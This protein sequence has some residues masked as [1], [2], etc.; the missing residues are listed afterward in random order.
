MKVEFDE[1][2]KKYMDD[3][4]NGVITDALF[5]ADT[6]STYYIEF[7]ATD[8]GKANALVAE[9]LKPDTFNACRELGIDV[10]CIALSNPDR[11]KAAIKQILQNAINDLDNII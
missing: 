5:V 6:E 11:K 2:T 10:N 4:N 3:I 8:L 1:R 7:K 9:L